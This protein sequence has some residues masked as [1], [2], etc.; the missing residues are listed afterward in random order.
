MMVPE[1]LQSSHCPQV[2]LKHKALALSVTRP[3]AKKQ[4]PPAR[5]K[6]GPLPERPPQA[7]P[8]RCGF[9]V[10]PI[11]PCVLKKGGWGG[12]SSRIG[13]SSSPSEPGSG[14][15]FTVCPH[16]RPSL[17]QGSC[18][19]LPTCLCSPPPNPWWQQ[20]GWKCAFLFIS[21]HSS[22]FTSPPFLGMNIVIT[23][24][25]HTDIKH[26]LSVQIVFVSF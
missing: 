4:C 3:C 24:C 26:Y 7:W 10:L 23:T 12:W 11:P 8:L 13:Q 1:L 5:K 14:G 25:V 15:V 19:H 9:R 21:R 2:R 22:I 6:E 17:L 20:C 16:R 18:P